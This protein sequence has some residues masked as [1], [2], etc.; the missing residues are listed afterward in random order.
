MLRFLANNRHPRSLANYFRRRRYARFQELIA[1][2]PRP[3]KILDIGGEENF[4]KQMGVSFED[5]L[6]I[7]LVNLNAEP[8]SLPFVKSISGNACELAVFETGSFDVVFSN[9]VIEHVGG[10]SEQAAMAREVSR[11]GKR[12]YIQTPARSFPIEPHFLIPFYAVLPQSLR[13]FLLRNFNLG[14]YKKIPDRQQA[15]SFLTSFQLLNETQVRTLFP[16]SRLEKERCLGFTKSYIC[17]RG[18]GN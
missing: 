8:V 18:F 16:N 15:I 4:W 7:T 12:F 11:I 14:W 9:S 2:L 6:L 3:L 17:H 1:S 13:I 10:F 5:G